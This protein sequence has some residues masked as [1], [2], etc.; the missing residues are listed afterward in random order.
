M[1]TRVKAGCSW[2]AVLLAG[3]LLLVPG[4]AWGGQLPSSQAPGPALRGQFS[5]AAAQG[6]PFDISANGRVLA[7]AEDDGSLVVT[8]IATGQVLRTLPPGQS[9]GPLQLRLSPDGQLLAAADGGEVDIWDVSTGAILASLHVDA[10][11]LAF[12][13]DGRWLAV[14]QSD[15]TMNISIFDA[16]TGAVLRSWR[17][18]PQGYGGV[19][20]LAFTP[21][22]R[23]MISGEGHE[24]AKEWD[25]TTG[26]LIRTLPG[27]LPYWNRSQGVAISPDGRYVALESHR[28]CEIVDLTSGI[29]VR[30]VAK[31][32]NAEPL[33]FSSD[34]L[35]LMTLAETATGEEGP[36]Q[37]EIAFWD[38]QSGKRTADIPLGRYPDF[39]SGEVMMNAQSNALVRFVE[40]QQ[41]DVAKMVQ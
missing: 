26:A 12:G 11:S 8:D 25:V 35:Q 37:H 20:D 41:I 38:V 1:K 2:C 19:Y 30:E 36:L 15:S 14:G 16:R 18:G 5:I 9:G 27:E 40:D 29:S 3:G 10:E 17:A 24:Q 21:D 4:A 6:G 32:L 34:G 28:A 31:G 23:N 13:P 7:A 33:A 22:G 39:A